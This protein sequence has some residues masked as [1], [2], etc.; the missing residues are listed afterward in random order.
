[1]PLPSSATPRRRLSA[2]DKSPLGSPRHGAKAADAWLKAAR[3]SVLMRKLPPETHREWGEK[4]A[5]SEDVVKL[6]TEKWTSYGVPGSG[7]PIW[8]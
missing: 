4:I 8:K 1:M 2:N 7:K 5:M 6:V 3:T